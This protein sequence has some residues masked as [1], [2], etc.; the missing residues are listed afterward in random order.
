MRVRVR[1]GD[2]FWTYSQIFQIPLVL[3]ED[4]NPG[5]TPTSLQIGQEINIPGYIAE[6]YSVKEN[7]TLWMIAQ[8]RNLP[9]EALLIMNPSIA[10]N[11][12]SINQQIVIPVRIVERIV[13][14]NMDY[15]FQQLENDIQ[16]LVDLY[17][18]L[19]LNI[20]GNSVLGK[21]LYEIELGR[22]EGVIHVNGSF[23]ANEW[24]TTPVIMQFINDYGLSL[25]NG[26]PIRGVFSLP[27]YNKHTLSI[28]P[29]VNPDGVDLVL[30]G[31]PEERKAEV[32]AINNGSDDFS[33]WK[34]NIRGVDLNNQYPANWEIEKER[35]E[36]KS[37]APRDF[38]GDAPLTEPEAIAMAALAQKK[39]FESVLA[40]HTQGRE[41]YWGYEGLE[42]PES[43]ALASEFAR[44]SGYLPVQYIDSHAGY[45]DW[46]IYI[47]QRPGFTFELGTGV[48]PLPIEQFPAIYEEMLGVFLVALYL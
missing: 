43:T 22:G 33:A 32:L 11:L 42:P 29:M 38:P 6:N 18:F 2:S 24:I 25:V 40:L 46:F 26:T 8:S 3:I 28:V 31:P 5:V 30:N 23:H 1:K 27:L 12:L 15:D 34:A 13:N 37:P 44:V 10:P 20:V 19:Q 35:K 48:N 45:K 4:S 17:P 7:D 16:Q 21:P 9:L 14:G 39:Q 47:Y 41:F 36:P